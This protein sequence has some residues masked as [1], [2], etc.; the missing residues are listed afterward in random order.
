MISLLWRRLY[1]VPSGE[2]DVDKLS[3]WTEAKRKVSSILLARTV[4]L[5][6]RQRYAQAEIDAVADAR[7]VQMTATPGTTRS[8]TLAELNRK[9]VD[10]RLTFSLAPSLAEKIIRAEELVTKQFFKRFTPRH[11]SGDIPAMYAGVRW[12]DPQPTLEEDNI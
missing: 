4:E 10:K 2:D 8:D 1:P 7:K 9:I 3:T 12:E 5:R 6:R 11:A